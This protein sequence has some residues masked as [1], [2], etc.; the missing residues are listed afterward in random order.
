MTTKEMIEKLLKALDELNEIKAE[1]AVL[2]EEVKEHKLRVANTTK[3]LESLG[4]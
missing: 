3:E 4:V 2:E 1:A